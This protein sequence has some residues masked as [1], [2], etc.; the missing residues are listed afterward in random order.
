[1]SA[2]ENKAVVRQLYEDLFNQKN[3]AALDGVTAPNFVDHDPDNPTADLAGARQYF[4]MMFAAFP[5][6]RVTVEDMIAEGDT[7]VARV[8]VSGTHQGEFLGIPPGGK[9]VTITGIDILRLA[10][11]KLVEHWGQFDSLGMMQQLGV[12]PTPGH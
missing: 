8:T 12:I 11:G 3:L 2:G 5:D 7:V 10:D 4:R 6:L 1:M 9:Q